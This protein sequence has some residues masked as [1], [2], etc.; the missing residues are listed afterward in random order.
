MKVPFAVPECD[1]EENYE[2]SYPDEFDDLSVLC[3]WIFKG[4]TRSAQVSQN[5]S[6]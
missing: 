5:K 6:V 2:W 3:L 4:G 1:H